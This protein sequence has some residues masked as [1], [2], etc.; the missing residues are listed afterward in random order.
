MACPDTALRTEPSTL[1]GAF[2]GSDASPIQRRASGHPLPSVR[3]LRTIAVSLVGGRPSF[4]G[5]SLDD[6]V[7]AG[8]LGYVAACGEAR[9][10][11]YPYQRARWAML[12]ELRRWNGATPRVRP[13]WC[14][15]DVDRHDR[16]VEQPTDP[17]SYDVAVAAIH[18][19]AEP[20]HARV[21]QAMVLDEEPIDV[22]AGRLGLS[23]RTV[24][25]Y[26]AQGLAAIRRALAA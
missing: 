18:R 8:W 17:E 9:T 10:A 14:A 7:S 20:A 12:D 21:V 1:F 4:L 6:L 11:S 5:L 25:N 13:Q 23:K 16:R 3:R 24:A 19:H 26:K 15:F 2:G 22:V